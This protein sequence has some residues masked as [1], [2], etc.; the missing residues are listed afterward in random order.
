MSQIVPFAYKF[1]PYLLLTSDRTLLREGDLVSLTPKIFETLV[2]LVESGGRVVDKDEL[3]TKIW[4]DAVVEE[5]N[6]A[7]NVS[8]LRKILSEDQPH[9]YIETIPRRGYRFVT[10][11]K[12]VS[13]ELG[14]ELLT[15]YSDIK[16]SSENATE[17]TMVTS[18]YVKSN[19]ANISNRLGWIISLILLIVCISLLF[20]WILGKFQPAEI[21]TNLLNETPITSL[22]GIETQAAFSPDGKQIAFAWSDNNSESRNIFVKFIGEESE[23]RLTNSQNRDSRPVWLPDGR[24]IIFM[25]STTNSRAYYSISPLGGAE[26]KLID[27]F[28]YGEMEYGNTPYCSPD[29]K[30]L[31]ISDKVT[32][33]EPL[34]LY[35]LSL[36][37]KEKQKITTPPKGSVGD[38]SAALSPDGKWIAFVRS[39]SLMTDEIYVMPAKGGEPK[40]ITFDKLPVRGLTWT[41]DSKEL[42]YASRSGG[43]LSHL[44]RIKHSGGLPQRLNVLGKE[45]SSP[46]ISPNNNRLI[47]SQ[48]NN[49]FNI[50]RIELKKGR[51]ENL[52]QENLISSTSYDTAPEYSPDGKKIVFVSSRAGGYE[53][54]VCESDGSK[55]RLLFNGGPYLTGTPRWSP[56]GKWV[57][58][59]SRTNSPDTTGNPDIYII[60]SEG[61]KPR[62][63]TDDP[64][65]NVAPSWSRDGKW[66]YFGSS[67]TGRFEIW[68]TPATGGKA[69]QIT[70]NGGFEAFESKDGKFIYYLK[71]R[72]VSGIWKTPASGGEE[73]LVTNHNNAGFR[74]YWRLVDNGIYFVTDLQDKSSQLEFFDF[75]TNSATEVVQLS[76]GPDLYS[77][78]LAISPDGRFFLFAQM[79]QSGSDLIM[80]DNFK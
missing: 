2:V 75:S 48:V 41:A 37:T 17:P 1:G 21:V 38:Y 25:R 66:I 68:K 26:Q 60:N 70:K 28:P 76:I 11:V 14:S 63:I 57:A 58:F 40:Q 46:T 43:G 56:D 44:Y 55:P 18:L 61:G 8:T 22:Q 59:D 15:Q 72:A 31:V 7:K 29:G 73:T 62:L 54:W 50:W 47:Y 24:S 53:I 27:I 20:I 9:Q 69:I 13:E 33:E 6:L 45:A 78:G 36:D 10:Q 67:R 52:K 16:N 5:I 42:I 77:P 71:G 39:T 64:S 51:Q 12:E 79:D 32:R 30:Y 34:S 19:T 3:L 80:I 35:R 23:L 74:R 65:E 4:P 49:D